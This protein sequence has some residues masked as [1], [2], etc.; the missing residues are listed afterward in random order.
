VEI[1]EILDR[2]LVL[3]KGSF[4]VRQFDRVKHEVEGLFTCWC[5]S[6]H[7]VVEDGSSMQMS[8]MLGL[9]AC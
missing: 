1:C 5:R 8:K 7:A 2:T 3:S 4:L 9:L 6:V